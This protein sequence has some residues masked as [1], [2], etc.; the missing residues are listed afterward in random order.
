MT[1]DVASIRRHF[2]Y[3]SSCVYLNTASVGLAWNGLGSAAARFFDEPKALGVD[4]RD[5]WQAEVVRCQAALGRL[6]RVGAGEVSFASSATEALNRVAQSVRLEPGDQVIFAEDEFPSIVLAWSAR[7]ASGA[8]IVRVPIR[9]ESARTEALL[10]AICARTRILCVSNVHWCTGTRVDLNRLAE[11]CRAHGAKLIV[12]GVQAVGAIDV[13]A[14]VADMYIA[15]V[16]KWLLSGFGV[17]FVVTKEEFAAELTP[18]IRGYGNEPPSCDLQYAHLNYP[19][20]YALSASLDFL[21]NI[22][23]QSIYQRVAQLSDLAHAQLSHR[24]WCVATPLAARAG[25]VSIV[26]PYA[27]QIVAALNGQGVRV[28]ERAGLVRASPH[29]YNTE[30]EV[31]RFVEALGSPAP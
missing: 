21:E 1:V 7:A 19:G 13:D 27:M 28:E 3:L 2:P 22:G 15:S 5:A 9:A 17:A 10:D 25:I 4:G 23:W 26:H 29:F 20:I 30:S 31:L 14:S 16:F 8:E 18:A 12:D 6:L 11:K 24:G